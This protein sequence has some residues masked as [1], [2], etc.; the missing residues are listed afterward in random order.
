M[1]EKYKVYEGGVFFVTLTTVGWID[2]FT[3]ADYSEEILKNLN[4]CIENKGLQIYAFCLMPSHLHMV[5]SAKSGSLTAILRDFKSYTAKSVI[6]LIKLNPQESRK[7]WLLY[8][9]EYFGKKNR[10]NSNFQ[11]WKQNNH[12]VDLLSP[13]FIEEKVN[14]IHENPVKARI[15]NEAQNYIYS[16]ANPFC[17]LRLEAL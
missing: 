3:R 9:F 14:Y 11:F 8:M 17:G 6:N 2:V 4:Y 16:S 13:K 10:H 15:V 7:D 12:P 5:A 1:S